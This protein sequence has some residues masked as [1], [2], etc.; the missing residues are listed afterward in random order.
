[1]FLFF[2]WL[3][4]LTTNKRA[5]AKSYGY[6]S[7]EKKNDMHSTRANRTFSRVRFLHP[8]I[9]Y[10]AQLGADRFDIAAASPYLSP[11]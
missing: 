5:T 7:T 1:M 6:V 4:P 3:A 2:L 10:S 9:A 11:S 8:S